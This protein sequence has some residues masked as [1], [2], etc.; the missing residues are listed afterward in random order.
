MGF[1]A[2]W[3]AQREEIRRL[4]IELSLKS[5]RVDDLTGLLSR[6]EVR[7]S[8]LEA[9]LTKEFSDHK[10]TLR[11][12]AD[13]ASKQLGLPQHFVRDGETASVTPPPPDS[14]TP[15]PYVLWQAQAQRAADE[16]AGINPAPI[17]HYIE[18]IKES[19]NKYVIG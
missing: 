9:A 2:N 12:V 4:K 19:P 11:R 6:E 5:L 8:L 7:N 3:F 13:Q 15:D 1:W 18:V 10:K 17:E 14:G 16:E